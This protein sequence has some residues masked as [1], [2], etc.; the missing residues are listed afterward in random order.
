MSSSVAD[1]LVSAT[2]DISVPIV[3]TM[4][5]QGPMNFAGVH[6]SGMLVLRAGPPLSWGWSVGGAPSFPPLPGNWDPD[7]SAQTAA[8][9]PRQWLVWGESM[10]RT[11][12]R[13][14]QADTLLFDSTPRVQR[15]RPLMSTSSRSH[16]RAALARPTPSTAPN[17]PAKRCW[18]QQVVRQAS[19]TNQSAGWRCR[20][21]CH[22]LWDRTSSGACCLRRYGAP[23]RPC[24]GF[25]GDW[26]MGLES[27]HRGCRALPR[28]AP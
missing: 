4:W 7:T 20:C 26:R 24:A 13:G 23:Q 12:R 19:C 25:G 21:H 28:M 10:L 2:L 9:A 11:G 16:G 8:G 17:G 22:C 14:H 18:R 3:H 15:H 5:L 1:D 27:A 6:V